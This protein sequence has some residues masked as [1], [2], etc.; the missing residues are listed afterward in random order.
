MMPSLR[1]MRQARR[2]SSDT[3]ILNTVVSFFKPIFNW[4]LASFTTSSAVSPK[5]FHLQDG[6][7]LREVQD[8]LVDVRD[9]TAVHEGGCGGESG[10]KAELEGF[11]DL[12]DVSAVEVKFHG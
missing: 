6:D 9:T 1:N 5:G 10:E 3:G 8:H 12:L 7:L 11:V 2:P 4:R